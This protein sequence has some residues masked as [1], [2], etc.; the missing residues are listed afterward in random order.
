MFFAF[1]RSHNTTIFAQANLLSKFNQMQSIGFHS[2]EL[3]CRTQSN[4]Q[5]QIGLID[6]FNWVWLVRKSK[7]HKVKFL[8]WFNCWSQSNSILGFSPIPFDWVQFLNLRLTMPGKWFQTM[9]KCTKNIS[10]E[11]GYD[12]LV[13]HV[14]VTTLMPSVI[15]YSN[16][17]M[18]T[19]NLLVNLRWMHWLCAQ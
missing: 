4:N 16:S 7:S 19:W 18:S 3:A 13:C 6:L 17:C 10:K 11:L 5:V 14:F 1:S 15:K 2:T 9:S 12:Q 8:S